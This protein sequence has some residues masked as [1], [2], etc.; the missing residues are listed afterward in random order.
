MLAHDKHNPETYDTNGED[1]IA[2]TVGYACLSRPWT[3]M[4]P[5]KEKK[6]GGWRDE[7]KPSAWT[8]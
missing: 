7:H 1:H 2:D 5:Q 4:K 3:P 6:A 8:Y